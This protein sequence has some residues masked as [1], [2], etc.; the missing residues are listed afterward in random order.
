M[1]KLL[2]VYCSMT[3]NTQAAAEAVAAG[4][5]EAGAE[6]VLKAGAEAGPEDLLAC[7]AVVLASYDAFSYMGG[8]LKDFLDRAFYPTQGQ[9]TGKPY[10]AVLTH[11]GGGKGIDSL[12]SVATSFKFKAAADPVLVKGRPD[13]AAKLEL[14]ALGAKLAKV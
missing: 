4:A 13:D 9:V 5:E 1:A 3:G 12:V 11:G 7:D 6:V 8:G 14:Q 10:A 2:I